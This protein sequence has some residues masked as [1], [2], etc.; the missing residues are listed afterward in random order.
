MSPRRRLPRG[1]TIA[2]GVAMAAIAVALIAGP[3]RREGPPLDP[4]SDTPLGTSALVALLE[5]FDADVELSVGLPSPGDDVA[6]VLRDRLDVEQ[7]EAVAAWVEQG[8][9][10]VV[11]DPGSRFAPAAEPAGL[12]PDGDPLRPGTCTVGALA[13]IGDVDGGAPLAYDVPAGADSCYGDEDSAFVVLGQHGAGEVVAVGGAA[14]VTNER[15]DEADNAVL[16]LALLAPERGMRVRFVDPPLPVGGGDESLADLVPGGVKRAL[17]QLAV[18][19]VL[20][21]LWRAVRL[22]RPVPEPQ[23]VQIAGS[24]LVAATGRLLARTRDP[25]AA[26]DGLREDRRRRLRTRLGVSPAADLDA[27]VA[28]T[29]ARTGLAPEAV[30][31]AIDDRPITTDD[32]LV[33]LTRVVAALDQEVPR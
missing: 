2:L 7:A 14:F 12:L 28:V 10:L 27:L 8:G 32:A 4:R 9:T 29:A 13:G 11:T 18:A 15:L 23:P 21:A 31:A 17:V 33:S 30:A 3:P 24:E 1:A 25:Q 26:A 6:L 22:G 20:Y 16:A 19:F 5:R